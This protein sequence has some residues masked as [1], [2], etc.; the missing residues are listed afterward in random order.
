MGRSMDPAIIFIVIQASKMQW[1]I[2][3]SANRTK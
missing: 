2:T 1:N 3:E